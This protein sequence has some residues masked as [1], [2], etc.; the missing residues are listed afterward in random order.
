MSPVTTKQSLRQRYLSPRSWLNGLN[1]LLR[2]GN[3]EIITLTATH[4]EA[5]RLARAR[6]KN[7][8]GEP[9]FTLPAGFI[10]SDFRSI[11]G[12]L[13]DYVERFESFRQPESNAVQYQYANPF[14]RAP[15]AE[16]L[17][18][19]MRQRRPRRVIEIGCGHSTRITR[20]AILDGGFPCRLTCIDPA[21]RRDLS[22]LPDEFI[23]G[24]IEDQDAE[25]LAASLDSND[26]LFIDTSHEVRVANDVAFIYCCLLPRLKSGVVVHIHD[27]FLPWDYTQQFVFERGLSNW[28]EQY[29]VHALI[30]GGG[31][32]VLW[33]GYYLQRTQPEFS[34]WFPHHN[35]NLMAQSLWLVRR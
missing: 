32:D 1:S 6:R 16:V 18:T 14:F 30:E 20:Q 24:A 10:S 4:A 8:F 17:Y 27:V 22:G 19:V 34:R 7:W 29:L 13:E 33:P 21:P 2:A 12:A 23:H 31:W 11:V 3:L 28:G 15:D 25:A 5:A 35:G 9:V 26:V